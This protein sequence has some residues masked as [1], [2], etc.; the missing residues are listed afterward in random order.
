[1]AL[2]SPDFE[3]PL[4]YLESSI[5][6]MDGKFEARHA[7][8]TSPRWARPGVSGHVSG[9]VFGKTLSRN[10]HWNDGNVQNILMY[11]MSILNQYV[12]RM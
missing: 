1:M 12:N 9:H 10:H 8:K 11:F 4:T 7:T 2:L 5:H 6:E 3:A